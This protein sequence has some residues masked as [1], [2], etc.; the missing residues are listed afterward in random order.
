MGYLGLKRMAKQAHDKKT[1]E[2]RDRFQRALVSVFGITEA[3]A[4]ELA[5][6]F[7]RHE[8]TGYLGLQDDDMT[9]LHDGS[10]MKRL[11]LVRVCRCGKP[12][13]DEVTSAEQLG[14]IL[15]QESPVCHS[16]ARGTA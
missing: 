5:E 10:N 8:P 3:K 14:A 11:R 2:E 16:C 15:S 12:Y 9:L 7:F 4:D 1:R 13:A 6:D